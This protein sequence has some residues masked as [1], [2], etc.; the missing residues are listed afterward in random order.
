MEPEH[1]GNNKDTSITQKIQQKVVHISQKWKTFAKVN[2]RQKYETKKVLLVSMVVVI[3]SATFGIYKINEIRTRG[4]VVYYGS[5]QVGIVR[6]KEE[7]AGVLEEIK[8]NLSSVH[9]C[10][11]VLGEELKFEETHAKDD[12]ITSVD[13]IEN[14]I[15]SQLDY[16]VNGYALLVNGKEV[17]YSK[18]KEELE[19]LLNN[20]KELY[21]SKEKENA[22]V[23]EVSFLEDVKIEE[24]NFPLN[25][26]SNGEELKKHI[27]EGGEEVKTHTVEVGE[28]LWTI[29]K[30]YDISVDDLIEANSGRDPEKLQI[31]DE[32]KLTISKPLVTVVTVEEVE[33]TSK[34]DYEVKVEYDKS[35]YK[36]Q[37]KVKVKGEKGENKYLAKVIKHNGTVVSNEILKEEVVKK[38][39][40]QLVVKG[41]KELP[42]TVATG[43]F[44][45][46]TRG[47]L[48][49]RYG[50]R[51]GR[52]HYG[53][54]IATSVGTP[55]KAAD[56][57]KVTYAGY[58]GSYGY[59]V[60]INHGN[61][62]VTRY[63]HCNSISVKAGQRVAKGQV[64][65]TVG[66]T[67]NSKGPHLHFEVLKNG[68]NVNPAGFVY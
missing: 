10:E 53:L 46:P 62:Y 5:E 54:D 57:G 59:L 17:G 61:G 36:T 48:T 26:L 41:T 49:S 3:V 19:D 18:S 6:E 55:I 50:M 32:V 65:A 60:E 43:A 1:K 35:M 13:E 25:K 37:S 51:N 44:L 66:N 34:V 8:E 12:K 45:M 56:G 15:R 14:N 24:K 31:G 9:D 29:A 30:L 68:R 39:V 11:I 42:K 64:I 63:A 52:M 7:V 16:S 28:S 58:R 47:R 21:A 22:K 67:G 33:Y 4:Y 38:P 27:L 23:I 40:N 20:L 2:F